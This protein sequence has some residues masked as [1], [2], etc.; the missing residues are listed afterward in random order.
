ML[1]FYRNPA[2]VNSC[3]QYQL[4]QEPIMSL[5]NSF[6]WTQNTGITRTSHPLAQRQ[7]LEQK[8]RREEQREMWRY[9]PG[10]G[11]R[12][13]FRTRSFADQW[14][15]LMSDHTN[16]CMEDSKDCHTVNE[17]TTYEIQNYLWDTELLK[18]YRTTTLVLRTGV[19]KV[20]QTWSLL[21][22]PQ[23]NGIS[24]TLPHCTWFCLTSW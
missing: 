19:T 8:R 17:Q 15:N 22:L 21:L 7:S 23:L 2:G 9:L 13:K 11:Q 20:K 6:C 16:I 1:W 4:C 3:F 10:N 12:T 18:G 5:R 24:Q 14:L